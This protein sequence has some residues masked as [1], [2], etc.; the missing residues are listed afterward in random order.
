MGERIKMQMTQLIVLTE[1]PVSC[2]CCWLRLIAVG[3][4]QISWVRMK[5]VIEVLDCTC[6]EDE[7]QQV[8]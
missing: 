1:G 7:D 6:F 5:E 4:L 2:W 3:I 8:V